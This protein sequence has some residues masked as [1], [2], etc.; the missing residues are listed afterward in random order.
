MPQPRST[1]I[2]HK[3]A[4]TLYYARQQAEHIGLDL[5]TLV[6]I[7]FSGTSIPPEK[8]VEAFGRLRMNHFNK[9]CRRPAKG[10]GSPV[11][12][13]YRYYFENA[14]DGIAFE[15][16]ADGLSHNVHVHWEA[17]IPAKRLRKFRSLVVEWL[18]YIAGDICAENSVD[19]RPIRDGRGLRAYS[20]KGANK[21]TADHFGAGYKQADQ[22]FII[23]RRTGTSVNI[24]PTARREADKARGI[25]RRRAA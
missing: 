18:D 17:C 3:A 6:T 7:N 2:G 25:W 10:Q 9:W 13:T 15:E 1:A 23:G 24:G 14:R 20:L 5:N 11:E 19:V 16:I 22:G 8:A 12:P 21:R 4:Q